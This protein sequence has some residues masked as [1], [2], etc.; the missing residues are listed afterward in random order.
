MGIS[1]HTRPDIPK[2]IAKE[3][4]CAGLQCLLQLMVDAYENLAA[5]QVVK[6]D[7]RENAIT[8]EWF[9]DI[10][11]LWKEKPGIALIPLL[12]KEDAT[13]TKSQRGS[14]PTI[15]FCFRDGFDGRVYFGAECKL[16][17]ETK[18]RY[19]NAY[20]DSEEGI[21]R[22]LDGRYA[23]CAG[24]GAMVGYVRSGSCDNVAKSLGQDI[25]GLNGN[26]KL[27][28]SQM[29]SNFKQLY[30]SQHTRNCPIAEFLCYHL[31]FGFNCNAA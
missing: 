30:E 2:D 13:K 16:L 6:I 20:L 12:Q 26:P 19:L 11:L 5:R 24:A 27:S 7:T 10:S 8:E 31:L 18:A 29:L 28:K 15:D 17:D 3:L 23:A 25:Q 4:G 1:D 22:F 9:M 14:P 21:G